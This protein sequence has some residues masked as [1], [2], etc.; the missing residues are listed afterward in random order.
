MSTF[1]FIALLVFIIWFWLDSARARELAVAI[2]REASNRYNVQLL[3]ESVAL[4]RLSLRWPNEGL[5]L[6]RL[7]TFDFSH[8][9]ADRRQGKVALTGINL[10]YIDFDYVVIDAVDKSKATDNTNIIHFRKSDD[11]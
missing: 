2:C 4:S 7:Y 9:G 6:W 8:D 10:D 11:R 5:R 3:D 1:L